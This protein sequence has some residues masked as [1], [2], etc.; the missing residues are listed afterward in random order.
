MKIFKEIEYKGKKIIIRQVTKTI[1]DY[2]FAFDER[3]YS[4]HIT[5]KPKLYRYFLKESFTKNEI[6]SIVI[7]LKSAAET[8]IDYLNNERTK[9]N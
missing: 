6:K 7:Y 1:F 4:A 8:T 9:R 5:V 2:L 3:V